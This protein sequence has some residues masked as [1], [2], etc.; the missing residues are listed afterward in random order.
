MVPALGENGVDGD[1]SLTLWYNGLVKELEGGW[2]YCVWE[3]NTVGF[4]L[5]VREAFAVTR[6]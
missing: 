5:A 1:R 4:R 2:V 6:T 3:I